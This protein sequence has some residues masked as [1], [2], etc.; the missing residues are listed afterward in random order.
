MKSSDSAMLAPW[1]DQP[2]TLISTLPF[3]KDV[4]T[5]SL[6]IYS[7]ISTNEHKTNPSC[8]TSIHLQAPHIPPP[9]AAADFVTYCRCWAESMHQHQDAE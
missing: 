3:S 2:Y 9:A 8:L 5:S 4:R 1:A 6:D 7:R